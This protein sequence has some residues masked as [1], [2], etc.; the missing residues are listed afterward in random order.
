M[1]FSIYFLPSFSNVRAIAL[2]TLR[3]YPALALPYALLKFRIAGI[4][5]TYCAVRR[6]WLLITSVMSSSRIGFAPLI[7]SFMKPAFSRLMSRTMVS[8]LAA[9]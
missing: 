9:R 1:R 7:R 6:S 8:K 4:S 3:E 2:C 5:P